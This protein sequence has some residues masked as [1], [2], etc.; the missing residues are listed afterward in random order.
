MDE[1]TERMIYRNKNFTFRAMNQLNSYSH[2]YYLL[3]LSACIAFCHSP[4]QP[5]C[6]QPGLKPTVVVTDKD[7]YAS[8]NGHIF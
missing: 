7:Y 1:V 3:K 4:A 6:S 2:Y 5:Y 8:H